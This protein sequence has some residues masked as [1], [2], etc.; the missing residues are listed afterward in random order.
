MVCG[1]IRHSRYM[2]SR[3]TVAFVLKVTGLGMVLC[4]SRVAAFLMQSAI[5]YQINRLLISSNF[6]LISSEWGADRPESRG[7]CV[8]EIA[9]RLS[10][11]VVNKGSKSMFRR[12]SYHETIIEVSFASKGLAEF[13]LD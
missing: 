1:Q 11:I 4:E 12:P 3:A 9:P 5:S 2:G 8:T 10:L 7:K 6:V 13:I